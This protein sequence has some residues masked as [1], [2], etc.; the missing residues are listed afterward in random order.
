MQENCVQ[1]EFIIHENS[2]QFW[3]LPEN[4]ISSGNNKDVRQR[5]DFEWK[6]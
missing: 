6:Q 1:S 3:C 4:L 5:R 2:I